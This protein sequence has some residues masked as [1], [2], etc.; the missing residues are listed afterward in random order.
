[1]VAKRYIVC[2]EY[3][4]YKNIMDYKEL[5]QLLINE[6]YDDTI[7][8]YENE[9]FDGIKYNIDTFKKLAIEEYTDY[10]YLKK[11][12]ISYGWYI[13]DIVDLYTD[14]SNFQ[15]YLDYIKNND[16]IEDN[17]NIQEVLDLIES[18]GK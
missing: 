8:C 15:A 10:E 12:L 11:E 9:N 2:D 16:N 4:D 6:L 14:L 1:M 3:S 7:T 13:Q 18:V 5:K 17:K